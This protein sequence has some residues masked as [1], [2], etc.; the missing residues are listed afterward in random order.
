MKN[1]IKF[2]TLF[3]VI[4]TLSSCDDEVEWRQSEVELTPVYAITDITGNNA[5][6]VAIHIYKDKPLIIEYTTDVNVVSFDSSGYSD[7][8]TES[9]YQITV[10]K[11]S[12]TE[13]FEYIVT[14][15]KTSG[16]GTL[17]INDGI[18]TE[19][20]DTVISEDEVYN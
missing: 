18:N 10:I 2:L 11:N 3:S 17:S 4:L 8:S 20:Y 13:Q 12:G 16:V 5:P 7:M 9:N 6:A 1:I 19:I 15:D 14:G